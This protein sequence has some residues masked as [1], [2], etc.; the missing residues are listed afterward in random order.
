MN[1]W[2]MLNRLVSQR[3]ARRSRAAAADGSAAAAAVAQKIK[4]ESRLDD[5]VTDLLAS[6]APPFVRDGISKVRVSGRS[7][8]I[9][10]R[11]SSQK[12]AI[13]RWLRC[14]GKD[15]IIDASSGINSVRSEV[16]CH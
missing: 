9:V 5:Q 16:S 6:R 7:V 1:K 14:G 2:D 11:S 3:R 12:Y 8:V 15:Q 10:C 13:D 4:K